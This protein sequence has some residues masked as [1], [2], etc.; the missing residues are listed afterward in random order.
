MLRRPFYPVLALIAALATGCDRAATDPT[1]VQDGIAYLRASGP[2]NTL[3]ALLNE[4]L[5]TAQRDLGSKAL[6]ELASEWESRQAEVQAAY[7]AHDSP[8]IQARLQALRAEE[9]RMILKVLGSDVVHRVLAESNA[10][11]VDARARVREATRRGVNTQDAESV[12][13]RVNDQ[14]SQATAFAADQPTRALLI[15]TEAAAQLV[16]IN[17]MTIDLRRLRGVEDLFPAVAASVPPAELRHHARLSSEARAAVK[18]GRRSIATAKLNEL[19]AEEIRI[20]LQATGNRAS[21]ELVTQVGETVTDLETALD[22]MREDGKE[23]ARARRMLQVATD[24]YNRG[25]EAEAAGDNATA[26][27]LASHA[28]GLLN[29]LRHLLSN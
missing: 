29:S 17:D 2:S 24:M 19:R 12:I 5:H 8:A 1:L 11:L 10:A 3:P 20:V 4:A 26:L 21:R 6:N 23:T 13:R 16:S 25:R 14:L 28:A 18:S 7:S 27:D 22:R 9:A 15:A